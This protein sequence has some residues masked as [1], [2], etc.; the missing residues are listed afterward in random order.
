MTAEQFLALADTLRSYAQ[1][2]GRDLNAANLFVH[3]TLLRTLR[4]ERLE[5]PRLTSA[6]AA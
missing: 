6:K 3:E 5:A 1:H 2:S 4:D